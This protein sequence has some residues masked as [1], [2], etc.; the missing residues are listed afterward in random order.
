MPIAARLPVPQAALADLCRK[1]GIAELSLFGSVL[2]DNFGPDSDVDVLIDLEP[3]RIM[4]I[5]LY[6]EITD[7]LSALFAGRPIHLS[8]K[9]LLT[10]PYRRHDILRTREIVYAA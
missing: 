4:T 1:H 8:Q 10:N 3:G 7:A 5:E 6:L 9:K 2:R